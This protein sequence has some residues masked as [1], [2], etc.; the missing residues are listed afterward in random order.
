MIGLLSVVSGVLLALAGALWRLATML[1]RIG[2][3]VDD[4]RTGMA[5]H[6]ASLSH[7]HERVTEHRRRNEEAVDRL[8]DHLDRKLAGL[9]AGQAKSDA[10]HR[11]HDL[12]RHR[13]GEGEL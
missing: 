6:K 1:G 3:M 7:V 5:E 2:A 12:D 4:I 13:P 9:S 11:L 8:R 10:L